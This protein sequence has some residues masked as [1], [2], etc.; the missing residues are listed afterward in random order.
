M[1]FVYSQLFGVD[2]GSSLIP[3]DIVVIEVRKREKPG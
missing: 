1:L 2:E 3:L